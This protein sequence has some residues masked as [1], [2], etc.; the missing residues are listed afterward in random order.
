VLSVGRRRPM[1]ARQVTR[2]LKL[3]GH[4][5][6]PSRHLLDE[7]PLG[8]CTAY[9][10]RRGTNRANSRPSD[11]RVPSSV[12]RIGEVRPRHRAKFC[13]LP[14]E[15]PHSP[16]AGRRYLACTM[17]CRGR[18]KRCPSCGHVP[19]VVDDRSDVLSRLWTVGRTGAR[20]YLD[21]RLVHLPAL[22]PGVVRAH[23]ERAAPCFDSG[24]SL[25]A[26]RG[27]QG[28]SGWC[29]RW[30]GRTRGHCLQ[31]CSATIFSTSMLVV[32]DRSGA[33]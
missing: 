1:Q 22:R 4:V 25:R 14:G 15:I 21:S 17:R 23:S 2:E 20:Q 33:V 32:N 24:R 7:C 18:H 26:Q 10:F 29:H 3:D 11:M 12:R 31:S 28:A 9:R 8:A 6:P 27:E 19:D 5:R 30:S 13:G 16:H